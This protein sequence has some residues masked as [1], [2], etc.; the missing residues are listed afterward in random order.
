MTSVMVFFGS[1]RWGERGPKTEAMTSART[2]DAEAT[3]GPVA[4]N[5]NL[6][7]VRRER[8]ATLFDKC[9]SFVKCFV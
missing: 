5:H 6:T 2:G 9:V 1:P 4:G 8:V 7:A 3:M